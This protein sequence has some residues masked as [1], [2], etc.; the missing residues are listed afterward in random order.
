MNIALRDP[1]KTS[2]FLAGSIEMGKAENWQNNMIKFLESYNFEIF[3]PRRDDWDSSWVQSYENSQF[4]QQVNW[5][6]NALE[7]ADIILMYFDPDTLSPI[8]LLETGLFGVDSNMHIVCPSGYWRKGNIEIVCD[9][10]SIPLYDNLEEFKTY[11][12]K[13]LKK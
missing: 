11:I 10:Y 8:S 4:Y 1:L 9:R 3:N 2:I 5:E 13:T 12:E 7:H 6:L